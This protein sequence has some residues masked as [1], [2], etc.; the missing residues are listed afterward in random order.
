MDEKTQ[1]TSG[2]AFALQRQ[3]KFQE[4]IEVYSRLYEL[5]GRI[6][7][8]FGRGTTYLLM[9]DYAAALADFEQVIATE[10]PRFLGDTHFLAQGIAYWFLNQPDRTIEVWQQGLKAPYTDAAGGVEL[11]ALLLYA[12]ERLSDATLRNKALRL[13]KKFTKGRRRAWPGDVAPFLLGKIDSQ[14]LLRDVQARKS[15]R[16]KGRFQCQADFFIGLRAYIK[17]DKAAFAQAMLRCSENPNG[18]LH[19]EFY[20]AHWEVE[21]NFPE[22]AFGYFVISPNMVY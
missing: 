15:E 2:D 1:L 18:D 16:L 9:G 20:L 5:D 22:P 13:L 3:G 11:P 19:H 6:P 17:N 7:S 4:A 14:E 8:L 10:D 21:R 12:A